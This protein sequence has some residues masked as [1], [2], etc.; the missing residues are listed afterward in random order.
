MLG[1]WQ[2]QV[3]SWELAGKQQVMGKNDCDRMEAVMIWCTGSKNLFSI[4]ELM[5][6]RGAT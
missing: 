6:Q 1:R 3:H 5:W 4:R 2:R